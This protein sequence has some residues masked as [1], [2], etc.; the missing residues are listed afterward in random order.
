M[1]PGFPVFAYGVH[2][3]SRIHFIVIVVRQSP[4][5]RNFEQKDSRIAGSGHESLNECDSFKRTWTRK[6]SGLTSIILFCDARATMVGHDFAN[7]STRVC[8][9]DETGFAE[10][11]G[12][13][14]LENA[15]ICDR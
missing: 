5:F 15:Q 8:L 6:R 9:R 11:G 3:F 12:R 10:K 2:A 7:R 14:L 4:T 13:N 1:K